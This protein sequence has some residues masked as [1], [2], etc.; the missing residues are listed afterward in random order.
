MFH[1]PTT[2]TRCPTVLLLLVLMQLATGCGKESTGGSDKQMKVRVAYAPVVINLQTFIAQDLG[3]F[4]KHDLIGDPKLFTSANDMISALVSGEIDVVPAVSLVPVLNLEAQKP[5][6]L[7]IFSHS[8]MTAEKPFDS[9]LVRT[10]SLIHSLEDLKAKKIAVFPGTTATNFLKVFLK[11]KGIDPDSVQY[12]PL[13][14]S[15]HLSS[16]QSGAVD[17]LFGYE[18]TVTSAIQSGTCRRIFGSVYAEL[19]PNSPISVSVISRKFEREHPEAAKRVV[20]LFD[21]AVSLIRSEPD[22]CTPSLTAYTKIAPEVAAK[23]SIIDATLSTETK[24]AP[25]QQ[26]IDLLHEMGE[27][28]KLL[29]AD[30]LL[31]PTN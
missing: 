4:N 18:P 12:V 11:R 10:D 5:G 16:L 1:R 22:K 25:I 24:A 6:T 14:P 23:V 27:V 28:P 30:D 26:F 20:E 9:I 19:Q 31:A 2:F 15:A 8:K 3:L 17:A 13:P 29:Q 7:R 21:G